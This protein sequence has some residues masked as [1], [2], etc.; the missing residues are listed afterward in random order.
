[1]VAN[2]KA[3]NVLNILCFMS[4]YSCRNKCALSGY[5]STRVMLIWAVL[6]LGYIQTGYL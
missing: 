1:M 2:A 4:D 6:R 3:K 5:Y